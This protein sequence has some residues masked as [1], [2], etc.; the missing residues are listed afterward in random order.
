MSQYTV[1]V[2]SEG[3]VD[4]QAETEG[5]QS[6]HVACMDVTVETF[7]GR[8]HHNKSFWF[9]MK[10]CDQEEKAPDLHEPVVLIYPLYCTMLYL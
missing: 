8:F 6:L 7:S 9:W 5:G 1:V 2:W 10:C 4:T 3:E